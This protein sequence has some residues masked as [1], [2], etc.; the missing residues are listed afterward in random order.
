MSS[1]IIMMCFEW[2][3]SGNA[4]DNKSTESD[5]GIGSRWRELEEEAQVDADGSVNPL[6]NV[7]GRLDLHW[8]I[9]K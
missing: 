3:P 7:T 6:D 1:G 9:R 8:H 4:Y 2:Q 5:D